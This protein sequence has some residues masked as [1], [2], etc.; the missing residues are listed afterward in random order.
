MPESKM[1][2]NGMD[3]N[4][5][6]QNILKKDTFSAGEHKNARENARI[7]AFDIFEEIF[8]EENP[9]PAP[10]PASAPEP[11]QRDQY[12]EIEY[13]SGPFPGVGRFVLRSGREEIRKTDKVRETEESQRTEELPQAEAFR[14]AEDSQKI[15]APQRDA[16][17][18]RF[19][20][21]RDIAREARFLYFNSSK[22]Y[23]R[24][25]QQENSRI[26]YKQGMFMEDFE[27][28]FE[29]NVPYSAYYPGYQNMGY[30]QLR[31][32]FTWRT[33]VR[34]GNI[35]STSLSYAFLYLYE[36][37]NNI[38]V[39]SPEEGLDRLMTF[40]RAYQRYDAS[41]DKYVPGW[42]KDYYIYYG[43]EQSFRE[44]ADENEL[45]S[46]YPEPDDP[47]D[48]FELFCSLSK[49]EI[50][51][52]V[53]YGQGNE[54]LLRNGFMY[55]IKKLEQVFED[56]H[57]KLES[58]LFQ[59]SKNMTRW[60]PFKGALFYPHLIQGDRQVSLSRKEIYV[61]RQ[62]QW[63]F[64][65]VLTTESGKKFIGYVM[66]QTEAVLRKAAKYRH[67]LSAGIHMLSPATAEELER[68]GIC[69]E[70]LVTQAA[71]EYYRETKKTVVR[72]DADAL[73]KI[74]RESLIT[75]EKLTVPEETGPM[76]SGT[77]GSVVK[78]DAVPKEEG[79]DSE[80][81]QERRAPDERAQ[82]AW[83]DCWPEKQE[84]AVLAGDTE[85]N[86]ISDPWESFGNLLSDTELKAVAFLL[87]RQTGEDFLLKDGEGANQAAFASENEGMGSAECRQGPSG[88]WENLK[89]FAD[90]Y[91]MMPE[92]LAEGINDKAAEQTGDSLLDDDFMIYEDYIEQ[93]KEMVE[94]T[95]QRRYLQE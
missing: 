39:K 88:E 84:R 43:S 76:I 4:R 1:N 59:P 12:Y 6:D 87:Y 9:E 93:A 16:V 75:Q 34:Q 23:D 41:V 7:N 27:D 32:Y 54:D 17:R 95:W 79:V 60:T 40:W 81:R 42:L 67:K 26:F 20:R 25:V 92:V 24:R 13:D 86:G 82:T 72:I 47:D 52:S 89:Q 73:E 10:V 55:V 57:L 46:C 29:K 53:F 44:F 65:T 31:T 28:H 70:E 78:S 21:M 5:T 8:E 68:A 45:R 61:C 90:A 49:Y 33:K 85:E 66:K 94:E 71:L 14:K 3:E 35:E 37:L 22:F 77:A 50:R 38:G 15:K 19:D 56:R 36:L 51:K 2:K 63:T 58:L 48:R 62:N 91:G 74:R 64:H 80:V 11:L 18:E 30:E 69:L 83:E